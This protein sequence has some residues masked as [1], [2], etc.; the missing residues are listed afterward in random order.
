MPSVREIIDYCNTRLGI[1]EFED[2]CPNGLQVEAG[3]KVERVVTGVTASLAL[4]EAARD[5]GAD[6][7]LV[8]HGYFWK[9]ESQPL[10]GM[11]GRRVRELFAAGLSM[12]AYHLPLDAHPELGNNARLGQL[13]GFPQAGPVTA[14]GLLW[15][16]ELS[17]PMTLETLGRQLQVL[18]GRPPLLLSGGTH[19]VARLAW[20]TGGAQ[21]WLGK[22][23]DL[24]YDAFITGEVSEA[25]FHMAQECNIH[26]IAAGHHATERYGI[27]ALG[28][29]LS[30]RFGLNHEY[31]DIPNP[32]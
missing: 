9:G 5:A 27:Q 31:I 32:V 29:E 24:D 3:E 23:A 7:L 25:S 30:D 13:L 6:L 17:R 19:Q 10:T 2:Y 26:F 28:A 8:H 21:S 11:K 15:G 4:I 12:A 16:S 1:T 20:C 14:D 22:A 18:T